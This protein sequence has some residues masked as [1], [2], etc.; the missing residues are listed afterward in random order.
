MTIFTARLSG[1]VIPAKA[2]I[3]PHSLNPVSSITQMH[4]NRREC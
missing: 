3:H 2:G 4:S 1:T